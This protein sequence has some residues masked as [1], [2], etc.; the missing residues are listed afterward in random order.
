MSPF[1]L[2]N[3]STKVYT[4]HNGIDLQRF[5]NA[6]PLSCVSLGFE[7]NDFI[8]AYSGRINPDKGVKELIQAFKQLKD[9]PDIKLMIVGG[10]FFGNEQGYDTFIQSLQEEAKELIN[11][12]TFTGYIPYNQI[13]SYLKMADVAVVP[14][15]WDEPFAL[16]L[17]E[18]MAVSLPV[19]ATDVGAI[20]EVSQGNTI[21]VNKASAIT[22]IT[23]S[24]LKLYNSP[25]LRT[26][27]CNV[28][29]I[30]SQQY[31]KE[32]YAKDFFQTMYS[33]SLD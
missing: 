30:L 28:G 2:F 10:S 26:S 20:A 23:Q 25:S 9:Y 11:T 15:M 18:A 16:T 7:D 6:T 12:I 33:L 24:I 22:E 4:V 8:V 27:M 32:R 19:I 21:L 17:I 3:P 29:F 31:A 5:Y 14:S 1:F 13:P